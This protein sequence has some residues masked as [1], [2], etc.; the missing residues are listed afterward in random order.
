MRYEIRFRN[1]TWIIFDTHEYAACEAFRTF[2]LA[3]QKF[4]APA[5]PRRVTVRRKA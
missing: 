4:N 1:G 3:E 5:H 2:K